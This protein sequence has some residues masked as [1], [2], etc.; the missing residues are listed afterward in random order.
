[1]KKLVIAL[2]TMAAFTGSAIAADMAPRT[3]SKAPAP[4]EAVMSWTGFYVQGGFGYGLWSAD[5]TTINSLTGVCNLCVN[6]QQGGKGWLG[7]VGAG[8]DW[9]LAPKWVIGVLGDYDFSDI[10]GTVQDQTPF[11][12][13]TYKQDWAWSAGA[14]IGY[15]IT[16]SVLSYFSAG[17]TEAHFKG[18]EAFRAFAGAPFGPPG[19]SYQNITTGGWFLGSGFEAQVLMPGLFVRSEYRYARYDTKDIASCNNA[20]GLCGN[21]ATGQN[22]IRFQ[23]D[24]Q[25]VRTSLVYKFNWGGPVVAKY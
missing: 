17:Y 18:S 25:T 22:S 20:T 7:T 9:Q 4:A 13:A 21:A 23:P 1:M 16:P 12:V 5:T 8:Y 24:V 10:K 6:Q 11:A 3:Y 19:F 2:A 14:R 15:L